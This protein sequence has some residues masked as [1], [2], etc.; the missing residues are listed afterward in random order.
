MADLSIQGAL[1]LDPPSPLSFG[2]ILVRTDAEGRFC[3]N[4]LHRAAGG[5]AKHQPA[6]WLRLQQTQDL[7]S[8][9]DRD[10]IPQKR[11]IESKQGL[12]TFVA[13]EL[14]IA[15]AAWIS[16]AFHLKVIRYFLDGISTNREVR[17]I[18]QDQAPCSMP[19]A[20]HF[21][22]SSGH[23]LRTA[24]DPDGGG[25]MFNWNDICAILGYTSSPSVIRRYLLNEGDIKKFVIRTGVGHYPTNHVTRQGLL[26]AL[27]RCCRPNTDAVKDWIVREVI[28]AIDGTRQ[29]RPLAPLPTPERVASQ[30]DL[31]V[32]KALEMA[33]QAMTAM[34]SVIKPMIR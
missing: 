1:A 13:R 22:F 33:C 27:D 23:T 17:A 18:E 26:R 3:L 21:V 2:E 20:K 6:N 15:Y 11:G 12:G 24:S 29:T 34:A 30:I 7:A 4:D 5:E 28:P 10:E 25:V 14:V 16:P 32:I 9:L 8:E 19:A 31:E